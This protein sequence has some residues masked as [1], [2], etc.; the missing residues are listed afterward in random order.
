MEISLVHRREELAKMMGLEVI[1][2]Y[3]EYGKYSVN[4]CLTVFGWVC[5]SV[6]AGTEMAI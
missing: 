1:P 2:L 4:V 5:S 6:T 3:L